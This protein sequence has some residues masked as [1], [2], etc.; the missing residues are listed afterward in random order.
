[1]SHVFSPLT[2]DLR[3]LP[4]P[5]AGPPQGPRGTLD[6]SETVSR[7][8]EAFHTPPPRDG[9]DL[10][11]WTASANASKGRAPRPARDAAT[12]FKGPGKRQSHRFEGNFS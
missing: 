9:P 8:L 11:S 4:F 1:M 12:E 3:S 6:Y 10:L 2:R 5:E 7:L